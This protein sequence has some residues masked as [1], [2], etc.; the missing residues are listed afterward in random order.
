MDYKDLLV[1]YIQ[2]VGDMEGV[3]FLDGDH[4]RP[5]YISHGEWEELK[6]LDKLSQ[7][8]IRIKDRI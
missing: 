7:Q 8:I 4:L 3:T 5:D 1:K 6:R 2:H